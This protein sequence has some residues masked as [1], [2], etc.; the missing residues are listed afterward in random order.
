MALQALG[1]M[2]FGIFTIA[3]DGSTMNLVRW[4][5]GISLVIAGVSRG[6][7]L[8]C[9]KKILQGV[10]VTLGYVAAGAA[11][12][13]FPQLVELA[14]GKVF[15]VWFIIIGVAKLTLCIQSVVQKISGKI[16]YG[17]SALISLVFG[18]YLFLSPNL[19]V[20]DVYIIAGVYLI[21]YSV[22]LFVDA[23]SEHLLF[24]KGSNKLKRRFRLP[25]PVFMTMLLPGRAVDAFN[26][27][28]AS[29]DTPVI[30]Q[31]VNSDSDVEPELEVYIH[32]SDKGVS[33]S[34][35]VDLRY[36]DIVYSY[37]CYDMKAHRYFSFVS[38][39][40]VAIVPNISKY[41][42]H[43]TDYEGKVLAGFGLVLTDEQREA[44]EKKLCE[45]RENLTEWDSDYELSQKGKLPKGE[46][47]DAA[48]M[49][50]KCTGGKIYKVRE[51][52]FKVYYTLSTNCVQ[53][54][55]EIL[56]A[57]GLDYLSG[58]GIITPGAYYSMLNELF[59]RNN[60]MV[61]VRKYYR[62]TKK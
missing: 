44:I 56:G 45:L 47:E 36:K 19:Y 18:V 61:A 6:F 9:Q 14:I 31:R 53:L 21:I 62:P 34:G 15:G 42:K 51:G 13:L 41:V 52:K 32:L 54:A 59:E 7:T 30:I 50:V 58:N 17:I 25:L 60:T 43:C 55:D 38:D 48:S 46:Y 10:L 37:G 23:F 2:L 49:L 16:R 35:H 1:I 29:D 57:A 5:A 33:R 3:T 27:Y 26:K 12:V 4:V 40:T 28:F 11:M 22:T 39:G 20:K 8:I 24:G